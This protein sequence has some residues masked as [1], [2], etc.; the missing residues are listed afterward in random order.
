MQLRKISDEFG[1]RPRNRDLS[2]KIQKVCFNRFCGIKQACDAAKIDKPDFD[3]IA[4]THLSDESLL[5]IIRDKYSILKR[6][7]VSSDFH[8]PGTRVFERRFGSF[9]KALYKAGVDFKGC[10]KWKSGIIM[11]LIPKNMLTVQEFSEKANLRSPIVYARIKSGFYETSKIINGKNY[12][13]VSEA[14]KIL[15][16]AQQERVTHSYRIDEELHLAFVKKCKENE[17]RQTDV[18]VR[19][20]SEYIKANSDLTSEREESKIVNTWVF[21]DLNGNVKTTDNLSKWSVEN[22]KILPGTAHQFRFGM[23]SLKKRLLSGSVLMSDSFKGWKLLEIY[24]KNG[25][26]IEIPQIRTNPNCI[27]AG[28]EFEKIKVIG[29]A[30][31]YYNL[32]CLCLSCGKEFV[33]SRQVILQNKDLGCPQC[34]SEI[35]KEQKANKK[36]KEYKKE[37]GER[38]GELIVIDVIIRKNKYYEHYYICKCDCGNVVEIQRRRV[39]SGGALTCGHNRDSILKNGKGI[40]KKLH[41]DG[42][43]ISAIDGTRKLNKNNTTG[44]VG[45][46]YSERLGGLYR[47]YINFKRKQYDLGLYERKEDAIKAR[48]EAEKEIYGN[49]LEW[50]EKEYPKI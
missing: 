17:E 44:H 15:S 33:T 45:V 13:N 36:L 18:I 23:S 7:L 21:S 24:D 8:E 30:E 49:F 2:D 39:R 11:D 28:D 32:K 40:S 10:E 29:D 26:K 27:M 46:S 48:E 16:F 34:A 6:E 38:F 1:H 37:I 42:T 31:E 35:R 5:N 4:Y 20:I 19:L 43:Y 12:I 9:K 14:D 22:E 41:V 50:Y 3:S 47:A 25:D